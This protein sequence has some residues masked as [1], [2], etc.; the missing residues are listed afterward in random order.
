M[1]HTLFFLSNS[2]SQYSSITSIA[3]K[4]T[5]GPI[6]LLN[7]GDGT[8]LNFIHQKLKFNRLDLILITELSGSHIYGLV[9][10]LAMLTF[11]KVDKTKQLQ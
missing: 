10:M 1:N 6:W 11:K 2:G 5:H 7:C 9:G 8:Q 4:F 3:F